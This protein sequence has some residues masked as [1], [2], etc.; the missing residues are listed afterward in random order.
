[1]SSGSPIA[2]PSDATSTISTNSVIHPLAAS[3][4]RPCQTT[5]PAPTCVIS[6]PRLPSAK[7]P[8]PSISPP[9]YLPTND[10]FP[11]QHA[12][13]DSPTNTTCVS[14]NALTT[15]GESR[16]TNVN[17]AISDQIDNRIWPVTPSSC[18]TAQASMHKSPATCQSQSP[19]DPLSLFLKY[20]RLPHTLQTRS[21]N[22]AVG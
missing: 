2:L 22:L 14:M 9:I 19:G 7:L 10:P 3:V 5:T 13:K 15:P 20:A 6:A 21:F 18:I 4:P 17:T 11:V 12:D 16:N 1:V 8:S